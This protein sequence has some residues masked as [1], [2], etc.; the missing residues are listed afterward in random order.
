VFHSKAALQLTKR[1]AKRTET[2]I[3]PI[4]KGC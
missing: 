4:Y 2:E 3:Q 1:Q